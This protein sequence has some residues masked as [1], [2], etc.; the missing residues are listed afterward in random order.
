MDAWTAKQPET[1]LVEWPWVGH[2]EL[3]TLSAWH[4]AYF[5]GMC[6][7]RKCSADDLYR[8]ISAKYPVEITESLAWSIG[9]Y[10]DLRWD[11]HR[12]ERDRLANDNFAFEAMR[13]KLR[14]GRIVE[15]LATASPEAQ[16]ARRRAA[17]VRHRF[18]TIRYSPFKPIARVRALR[19]EPTLRDPF[20]NA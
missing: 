5:D 10:L 9:H 8:E 20:R 4:W 1:R 14:Q 12:M 3:V 16:E 17:P 11:N 13:R 15:L 2:R 6:R 18:P 19:P 7:A